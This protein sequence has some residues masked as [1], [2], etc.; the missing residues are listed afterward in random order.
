MGRALTQAVG[1]VAFEVMTTVAA[2]PTFMVIGLPHRTGP[3]FRI[4]A[5]RSPRIAAVRFGS[6]VELD[7]F[8]VPGAL[9]LAAIAIPKAPSLLIA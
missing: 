4:A 1:E 5:N 2:G 9:I 8:A 3:E 7:E 6:R